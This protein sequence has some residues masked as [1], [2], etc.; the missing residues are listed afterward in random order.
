MN[1]LEKAWQQHDVANYLLK[2]TYPAI[3]DPKLLL[4]ILHNIYS[5][6]NSTM[7]SII[8]KELPSFRQKMLHLQEKRHNT[9]FIEEIHELINLHKKSPIEFSREGKYV[10]CGD[11][12][13]LR[14]ITVNTVQEYLKEANFLLNR[15]NRDFKRK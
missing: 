5:C 4:T 3:K 7:D 10:I 6:V 8:G 13:N 11:N 15:I 1:S 9:R 2:T 14:P 12:Y